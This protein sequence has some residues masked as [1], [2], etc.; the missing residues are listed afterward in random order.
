MTK[1]NDLEALRTLHPNGCI[2]T[3][4]V[5]ETDVK[6]LSAEDTTNYIEKLI[7]QRIETIENANKK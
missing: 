1:F 7:Q 3:I 2:A 4:I 6:V 5:E